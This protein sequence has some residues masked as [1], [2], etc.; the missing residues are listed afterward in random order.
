[1]SSYYA[2][3][4]KSSWW[5]FKD[6]PW[7]LWENQLAYQCAKCYLAIIVLSF[8]DGLKLINPFIIIE[9]L[10]MAV[11]LL[12]YGFSGISPYLGG[13]IFNLLFFNIKTC[14]GSPMIRIDINVYA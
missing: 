6:Y 7:H 8:S 12:E 9:M 14:I 1:M 3:H 4:L 2:K 13:G 5:L 11:E 10:E